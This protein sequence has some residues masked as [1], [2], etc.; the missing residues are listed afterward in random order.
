MLI[1]RISYG[2]AI[3]HNSCRVTRYV[4]TTEG[5]MYLFLITDAYSRM[6]LGYKLS[7][8]L[9]AINA[10]KAL[11]MALRSQPTKVA[12][13]VHHSDRGIL[14]CPEIATWNKS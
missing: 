2:L 1:V 9:K 13:L 5:F 7:D 12:G 8:N 3:L 4:T 14:T 11:K 6:I 10:V